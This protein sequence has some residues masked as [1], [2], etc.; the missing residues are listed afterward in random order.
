MLRRI[1]CLFLLFVSAL[2]LESF[3]QAVDTTSIK[4]NT[5]LSFYSY[6][7]SGEMVLHIPRNLIWNNLNIDLRLNDKELT[8]WKGIP[9]K[10]LLNLPF[11]LL[12]KWLRK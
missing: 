10:K 2:N 11:D 9:G 3:S 5:R 12:I 6:E 4:M 7:K 8:S 1:I